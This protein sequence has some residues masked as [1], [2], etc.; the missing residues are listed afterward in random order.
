MVLTNLNLSSFS[1]ENQEISLFFKKK[2]KITEERGKKLR[3]VV[4]GWKLKAME[5]KEKGDCFV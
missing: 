4:A 5:K 1:S 2:K 3:K